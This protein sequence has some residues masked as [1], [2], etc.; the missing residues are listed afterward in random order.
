MAFSQGA[1]L[2]ALLLAE[3]A[4][5][6]PTQREPVFKCAIFLSGMVP[7]DHEALAQG[8][9]RWLDPAQDAEIITVPTAHIWGLNDT[10]Y[11]GISEG[12][13][14]LCKADVMR[15]VVHKGG[16]EIPGAKDESLIKSVHAIKETVRLATLS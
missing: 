5:Y 2:A 9:I 3:E 14:K 10:E 6:R 4:S 11:P 12:L 1:A 13:S 8:K 15:Q 16:H 7:C